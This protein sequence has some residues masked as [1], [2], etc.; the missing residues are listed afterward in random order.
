MGRVKEKLRVFICNTTREW[1]R[2]NLQYL[3][4]A[5]NRGHAAKLIAKEFEKEGLKLD[6]KD[7]IEELDLTKEQVLRFNDQNTASS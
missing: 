4:V 1:G 6:K 3:A 2:V 5:Y 7:P